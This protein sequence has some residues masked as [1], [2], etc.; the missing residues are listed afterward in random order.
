MQSHGT[1]KDVVMST[2]FCSMKKKKKKQV[3]TLN[4]LDP[5]GKHDTFILAVKVLAGSTMK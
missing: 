4:T 3:C 1:L 2:A 5:A